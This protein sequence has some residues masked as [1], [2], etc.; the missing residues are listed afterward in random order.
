MKR[1]LAF[2]S[3]VVLSLVA[4]SLLQAQ[5]N[6]E[7]TW[8]LNV[9]TSKYVGQQ[10]PKNEART[11]EISYA[12]VKV[13]VNGVAGD[14]GLIIWSYTTKY[15]GKDSPYSGVGSTAEGV[16]TPNEADTIAVK[17]VDANT[18]TATSKNT[19][20]VVLTER[21]VVSSDGKVMTITSQGTNERGQPNSSSAVWDK[22]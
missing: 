1:L 7:G 5:S 16:G 19:G 15:D 2:A 11:Y 13:S 9:A 6:P 18:I 22:Q 8:K 12:G 21:I 17:R 4:S 3:A 14:G 10:A 20:K